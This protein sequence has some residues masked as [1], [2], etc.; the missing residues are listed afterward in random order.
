VK[1]QNTVIR[2]YNGRRYHVLRTHVTFPLNDS[3]DTR[4]FS[5]STF[6]N[7]TIMVSFRMRVLTIPR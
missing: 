7:H 5:E 4:V 3:A 6:I 1:V 2:Y